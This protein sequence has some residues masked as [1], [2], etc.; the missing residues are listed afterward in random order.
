MEKAL[1]RQIRIA[2]ILSNPDLE[3]TILDHIECGGSIIDLAEMY[4]IGPHILTNFMQ[5]HGE[6]RKKRYFKALENRQEYAKAK[7]LREIERLA[8]AD[9]RKLYDESGA[10]LPVHEWPA[11]VAA[12][13]AGLDVEEEFTTDAE[14]GEVM[15]VGQIK[16]LKRE[17]KIQALKMLSVKVDDLKPRPIELSGKVKLEDLIGGSWDDEENKPDE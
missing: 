15:K 3:D 16:K 17:S 13:V 12:S 8:H 11:D 2:Q 9:I 10:M 6:E 5:D 14:T 7:I 4:E 1:N